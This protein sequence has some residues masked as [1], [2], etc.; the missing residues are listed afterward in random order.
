MGG[1]QVEKERFRI[2]AYADDL[3]LLAKSK[4]GLK[5]MNGKMNDDGKI[6]EWKDILE[7]KD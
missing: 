3:V 2:L 5:K 4:E 6:E 7:G 1:T